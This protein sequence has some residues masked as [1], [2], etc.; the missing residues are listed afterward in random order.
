MLTIRS[1]QLKV[2]EDT[3]LNDFVLRMMEHLRRSFADR[4]PSSDERLRSSIVGWREDAQE[5]GLRGDP[6]IVRYLES[7][8]REDGEREP[9]ESR[10]PR[11]L[12]LH[13]E[14]MLAG[15]DLDHFVKDAM[16]FAA[17]H[18]VREEEGITWLAVILLAG[19]RSHDRDDRWIQ[20]ILDQEAHSSE[21]ARMR[22]VHDGA[23]RRGW[24]A[25]ER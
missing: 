2:F 23:A 4:V 14:N 16:A 1:E 5:W 6:Q 13:Y 7:R 8:A 24:I 12:R 19:R 21:E 10:L 17:Q 25:Q 18:H 9:L 3:A 22:L 20:G 15:V 11:Y